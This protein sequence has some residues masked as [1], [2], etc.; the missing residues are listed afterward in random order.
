MTDQCIYRFQGAYL[1]NFKDFTMHFKNTTTITLDQNY[2]SPQ[3][4]VKLASNLLEAVP[5]RQP[6]K[7]HSEN[8]EGGKI[9][10]ASCSNENAEVEF[11]LKMINEL[12]G[13]QI[14]EKRRKSC[15]FDLS[16][17]CNFI[18]KKD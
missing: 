9:M 12:R 18:Q 11:V 14:R 5:E 8:E 13:K 2:R 10:L 3:N 15:P 6:K 7:L 1:T 4:I 17:F 16:R